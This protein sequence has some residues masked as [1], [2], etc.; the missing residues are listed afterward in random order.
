M[1]IVNINGQTIRVIDIDGEKWYVGRDITSLLKYKTD[2]SVSYSKYI[3]KYT[4]DNSILLT[5][6][7]LIELCGFSFSRKGEYLINKEG[8][9]ILVNKSENISDIYKK[10]FIKELINKNVID[11]IFVVNSRKEINFLDQLE[12]ILK[13][14]GIKGIRQYGV[15]NYKIDFYI[16]SFNICI[17][18][19][20]NFHR[21]YTYEKHE[22]R[23]ILIEK[24]LNCNFIRISDDKS[25][26]ENIGIVISEILKIK[27]I[28]L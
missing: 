16:P 11:D 1:E 5:N 15:L 18:Y 19:D 12:E 10:K 4:Y 28:K 20:E 7:K 21:D 9:L 24:E 22:G 27:N 23:Q 6:K 17:E 26:L 14:I 8:I 25:D 2:S 3:K 13:P